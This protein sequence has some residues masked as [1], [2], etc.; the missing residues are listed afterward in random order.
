MPRPH[1][2]AVAIAKRREIVADL[3][4]QGTPQAVIG[5][6]VDASQ[7]TISSD[8]KAIKRHWRDS[9]VRDFDTAREVELRKL[10]RIEREAWE[11]WRRSQK[12]SQTAVMSTDGSDQK[13]QTTV[14]DQ[15]GDPRFLEQ[16]SSEPTTR[17]S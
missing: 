2:E 9:A 7:S 5:H 6:Q 13:T 8:L 11:A 15:V 3:Y 4:L 16:C 1:N 14:R 12:P 17:T 10:D